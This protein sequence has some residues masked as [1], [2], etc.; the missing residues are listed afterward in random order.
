M[1][2]V[3]AAG[4]L[5]DY[6]LWRPG[7]P[8][9]VGDIHRGRVLARVPA[10][11]GAFVAI[12]GSE[13]FLPDTQGARDVGAGA[14]VTVRLVRA[15]QGGK[16]PRLSARD[17]PNDL[18]KGDGVAL[19]RRGPDPV[20][21]LAALH[22]GAAVTV[23][24]PAL[25]AHT[26]VAVSVDR[27]ADPAL[28]EAVAALAEPVVTLPGSASFS[29]HPTPALVAIDVDLGGATGGMT[30]G[31]QARGTAQRAANRALMP[32]LARHI[33]LRDLSGVILIDFAG[34]AIRERAA[35]APDLAGALAADPLHPR[36]LGFTGA[37][38]AEIL[39][40][41]V[42]PPLHERRA[43]PLAAGLAAL[44]RVLTERP[45]ATRLLAAPAVAAALA[46]DPYALDDLARRRGRSLMVESAPELGP[47]G[48]RI[49]P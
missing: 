42:H 40:P 23:D 21:R 30:G 1:A 31:R 6:A 24:D 9:G 3:D 4:T 36:L 33:R 2:A 35:L 37:G 15:A 7:T 47:P 38:L 29:I 27:A 45:E 5:I 48:W 8:D 19:L 39:R 28:A 46:A 20:A 41:R 18:P 34:M 49:A 13:G 14:A 26:E 11:G 17:L 43:G 25:A 32:E 22:P 44:H 10:M 16:G 12:Y